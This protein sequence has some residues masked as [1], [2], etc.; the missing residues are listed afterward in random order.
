MDKALKQRSW[1]WV[2]PYGLYAVQQSPGV[3]NNHFHGC[4]FREK[5]ER[6]RTAFEPPRT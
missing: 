1:K 3:V 6:L 5:C 4:Y 2:A